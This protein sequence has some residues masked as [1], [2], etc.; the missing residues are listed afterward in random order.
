MPP[1]LRKQ[2]LEHLHLGHIRRDNMLSLSRFLFWW[3]S[4]NTDIQIFARECKQ[5]NTKPR[6]HPN[7]TP[8]PV[9]FQPMERLHADFC[10]PFLGQ[11]WALATQA[12]YSKFLE[13]FLTKNA[14]STFTKF[15]LQKLFSLGWEHH[16]TYDCNNKGNDQ[17]ENIVTKVDE[18][19]IFWRFHCLWVFSS[20]FNF[21]ECTYGGM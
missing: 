21:G 1:V 18:N 2:M 6:S 12:A 8:W 7:W 5:C 9:C 4:F 10:R 15:A 16:Y 13:V 11:Y 19:N 14:T 17:W 20:Y 3:P